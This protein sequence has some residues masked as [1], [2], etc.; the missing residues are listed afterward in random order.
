MTSLTKYFADSTKADAFKWN[1]PYSVMRHGIH[2]PLH[3]VEI[4]FQGFYESIW[5]DIGD[6]AIEE[7]EVDYNL[8]NYP[9]FRHITCLAI[10]EWIS[11]KTELP[12]RLEQFTSPKWYNFESH[13]LFA[14]MAAS[15][16]E[17][18]YKNTD[19]KKLADAFHD[20]L[21]PRSG[22]MPFYR[23]SSWVEPVLE[24]E[25]AQTEILMGLYLE[26]TLGERW[27]YDCY[28]DLYEK[29]ESSLYSCLD[30]PK[31]AD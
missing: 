29:L 5:N 17:Q 30:D 14:Y 11:Q 18:I 16:L 4:P 8:I 13:R 19:V 27:E 31:V 12:F 21:A 1:I 7:G 2:K 26:D 6:R 3:I 20:A 9:K 23:V 22:F 15:D 24:W 28:E 10:V 25:Y